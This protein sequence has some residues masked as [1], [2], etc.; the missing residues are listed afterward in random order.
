MKKLFALIVIA[1]IVAGVI[2]NREDVQRYV[3]M[4]RM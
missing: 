1:I 3:E 2:Q 4:R